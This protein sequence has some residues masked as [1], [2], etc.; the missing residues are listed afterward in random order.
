MSKQIVPMGN[1]S[2][3]ETKESQEEKIIKLQQFQNSLL[4]KE[5]SQNEIKSNK[6]ANNSRYIPISFLE[7]SLDEIFFGLWTTQNFHS[8]TVANEEVGSLELSYFHPIAQLWITRVGVAAVQI[9]MRSKEKGG[10]GDITNI[11]DKITNTLTKDYPHL[12]AECFRNAC[13]SIGKA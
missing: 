9:Q 12:K 5:P 3:S 1:N 10:S 6:Y 2:L 7:M 8:R 4:Q 13:M 11:S